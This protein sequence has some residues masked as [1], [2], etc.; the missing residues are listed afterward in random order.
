MTDLERPEKPDFG[1]L[2]AKRDDAINEMIDQ[3]AKE[4]GWDRSQIRVQVSPPGCYC[5]CPDGP[6][7][8]EFSGWREF[9]CDGGGGGGEQFC[10][11][12]GAGAMGHS[13]RYAP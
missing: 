6:C 3:M 13:M 10:Q 2:R 8:H 5:A 1:A 4:N 9:E 7:E 11:K 12:C